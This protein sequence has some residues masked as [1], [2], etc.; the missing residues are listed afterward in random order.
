MIMQLQVRYP[1]ASLLSIHPYRLLAI[2]YPHIISS[3]QS[4]RA[5][6][7]SSYHLSSRNI[8]YDVALRSALIDAVKGF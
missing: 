2:Q 3:N 7:P 6:V 8:K 4:L 1:E 5:V